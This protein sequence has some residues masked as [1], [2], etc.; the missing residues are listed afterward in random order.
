M[1]QDISATTRAGAVSSADAAGDY[2]VDE[3]ANAQNDPDSM[4]YKDR[5]DLKTLL[6]KLEKA[7]RHLPETEK[8]RL[9]IELNDLAGLVKVRLNVNS[10]SSMSTNSSL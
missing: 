7:T 8:Y 2:D 6:Q 3:P 1:S 4:S 5:V 9:G 10:Y